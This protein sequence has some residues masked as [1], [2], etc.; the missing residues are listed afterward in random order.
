[1]GGF[2]TSGIRK[3][4]CNFR[5][6]VAGEVGV[7]SDKFENSGVAI[8]FHREEETVT[9]RGDPSLARSKVSLKVMIR[10]LRKEGGGV[11][12]EL[13]R[14]EQR[15]EHKSYPPAFLKELL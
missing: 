14:L 10:V 3:F 13:N 1:M 5:Y 15:E 11:L 8:L 6:P 12:V 2:L 7:C 4:R 9:L